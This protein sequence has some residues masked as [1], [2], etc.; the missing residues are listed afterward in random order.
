ML[1]QLI[2]IIYSSAA[3]HPFQEDELAKLLTHSRSRNAQVG[4]T[5]M[6]L[7]EN[8]SFFQILEGPGEA[9]DKLYQTI[10]QDERHTNAV[11]IIREPIPKRSFGE[12][13]MGYS[14][15]SANELNEIIGLNDFF[16]EGSSFSQLNSGRA[17]KLLNAFREGRWHS[18]VKFDS[19]PAENDRSDFVTMQPATMPRTKVS[20]RFQPIID[21][22]TSTVVAY[23]ALSCGVNNEELSLLSSQFD[24]KEWSR[25][26]TNCRAV[27]VN[28]AARLG[29]SCGLHLNFLARNINDA[30]SAIQSTLESAERNGI[31]PN[32]IVLEIDQDKLIGDPKQFATVIEE[33]R[34]GGLR[35]AI[36]HFGAGLA[37]LNLL[38]PYR[39]EMI[40]LN[41][42]LVRNIDK[43][44]P[45]QAI[46]LGVHQ[47]CIDLGIDLIAKNVE[48]Y[49]EYTWFREQDINLIQGNFI[50]APEF[51]KLP[52]VTLP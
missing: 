45:R 18:K 19:P 50:A 37:G 16:A 4:I 13:T 30:R 44:G 46:V 21:I 11:V 1:I 35:I 39:P 3:I 41:Q 33:Y 2:H 42:Q 12:W 20:F 38:E 17:K 5:G 27:A 15:I 48:T 14:S 22:S 29:L 8:S 7:Y 47:T 9:V 31:D 25:F 34:S 36:D 23:E 24:E 51:E 10:A 43:N 52:S 6:L 28:L 40:C 32:F 26:D 49:A